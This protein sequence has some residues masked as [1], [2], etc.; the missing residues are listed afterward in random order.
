MS[1]A[2]TFWRHHVAAWRRSELTQSAYCREHGLCAS[3]F[4]T[5]KRRLEPPQQRRDGPA[6]SSTPSFVEVTLAEAEEA[7]TETCS[8]AADEDRAAA[9]QAGGRQRSRSAG[10]RV[11]I[12]GDL[13]VELDADFDADALARAVEVLRHA[14][15]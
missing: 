5:W 8:D 6:S 14:R 3:Q 15:R 13:A 12:G 2:A 10:L 1:D 9:A 7:S 11:E 4:S